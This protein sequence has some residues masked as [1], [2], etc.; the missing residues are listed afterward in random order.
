MFA[1]RDLIAVLQNFALCDFSPF[2]SVPLRE[3]KSLRIYLGSS[4]FGIMNRHDPGVLARNFR[5]ID[6][7]IGFER[8]SEDNL[9]A[10]KRNRHGNQITGQ[11]NKCRT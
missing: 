9:F 1:D 8:A 4:V 10:F 2:K 5:I 7:H 6:P 3:F 11:K